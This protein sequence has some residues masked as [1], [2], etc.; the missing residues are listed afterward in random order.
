MCDA[1]IILVYWYDNKN[2]QWFPAVT[3]D[4]NK[5]VFGGSIDLMFESDLWKRKIEN[6]IDKWSVWQLFHQWYN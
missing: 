5:N 1:V 2:K 3:Y 4:W 6:S